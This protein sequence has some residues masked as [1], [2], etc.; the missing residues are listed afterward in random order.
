MLD[1]S[2]P[3]G[4]GS[5][6][7]QAA[8]SALQ[9]SVATDIGRVR[10]NNEDYVQA[11]RLVRDG[12]RYSMWAVADGV[13]GG[14]QGER[15]SRAAVETVV[16]YLAH[17]PWTDPSVALTEAF[18]LANRN[19]YDITGEGAAASTLVVALVSEP[20]G[21]VCIA[22][23]GDSRA[24]LVSAGQLQQVTDDHSIVAARVAAGQLTAEEARTAPNRNI[25]TRSIGSET[26][27]LVD[28][29]GP[30]QLQPNELLVLC[31]DGVHGMIDDP[32]IA[33]I[34]SGWPIGQSAGALVAAAV[35]AGGKDNATA[36]VGGY[37]QVGAKGRAAGAALASASGSKRGRSPK[38]AILAAGV[39]VLAVI[40]ATLGV[41][42][43]NGGGNSASVVPSAKLTASASKKPAVTAAAAGSPTPATQ[44]AS[45]DFGPG[46]FS[47]GPALKTPRSAAAAAS[48]SGGR[49]LIVGGL[50]ANNVALA[51]AEIYDPTTSDF[52]LVNASLKTARSGAA[53]AELPD[54]RILVV[55]GTGANKQV[56]KSAEIY[57]PKTKKFTPVKAS[58]KTA[59]S[60]AAAVLTDGR[61]LVVGGT[62]AS[63]VALA[64]AEIYDPNTKAFRSA[65]NMSTPRFGLAAAALPGGKVLII[66]GTDA[67]G[68]VLATSEI[69]DPTLKKFSDGPALKTARSGAAASALSGGKVFTIGGTDAGGTFLATSEIYDPSTRSFNTARSI[70]IPRT[71][72]AAAPTDGRILVAGGLD[73]SGTALDSVEIYA[74]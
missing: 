46:N 19:V 71:G 29:F 49:I 41:L 7:Q 28:V 13:G 10:H 4:T 66:G 45:I 34:A 15:A 67:T 8:G 1:I 21:V 72:A 2:R 20:D 61:I 68:T 25:L 12:R 6:G 52:T 59:R 43:Y 23:V 9:V 26:E 60:G 53:A 44:S 14:P 27:V 55:G 58:L 50:D 56:L 17:E 37:V 39:V 57:D 48:L 74:Q 73:K 63:G 65:G 35:E 24:Y 30:R 3:A 42:A 33:R 5:V 38:V 47:D 18:A 70:P 11:E 31:T 36:L 54:G 69:Y 64:S 51:S 22:N 32:E 16:D 40:A 62:D